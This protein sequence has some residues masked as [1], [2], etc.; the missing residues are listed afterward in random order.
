MQALCVQAAGLVTAVGLDSRST[1]AAIRCAID[2]FQETRFIDRGGE[3]QIAAQVPWGTE[4]GGR[5][6]LIDM[7]ARAVAE[8]LAQAPGLDSAQL[9]LLLGIAEHERPGR[10]PNLDASLLRDLQASLGLRF[11]ASSSVIPRGRVSGA[12]AL[13]NARKLIYEQGHR[14]VLVAGVDSFLN[15]LTLAAYDEADRLLTSQNSNG[16]IPGEGASAILLSAPIASDEPQLAC[17]GLGFGVESATVTAERVA[18]RAEGLT[19]A[20]RNALTEANCSVEH[21]DCRL[22]DISGEQYYFKE[23]ALLMSRNLRARKESFPLVH[24]ADC[25]GECGAA[26]GPALLAIALT[27]ARKKYAEGPNVLCHLGN[28]AG[29]RAVALLSYQIIGP[30]RS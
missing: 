28:D 12:V 4:S 14:H 5:G 29:Q 11:H 7:A 21:F 22:T 30:A 19:R 3:W 18:L 10:L 20:L 6:K 16:F 17:I 9:V 8:A 25:I 2:N 26:I 15:A 13:L 23:A 1:C 27:A 24:P